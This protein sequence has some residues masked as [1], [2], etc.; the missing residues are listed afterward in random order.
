MEKESSDIQLCKFRE[1]LKAEQRK[2]AELE[3]NMNK[4]NNVLTQEH[5]Q[6]RD[7]E[8]K[9]GE[10]EEKL[11][12]EKQ[13]LSDFFKL[14]ESQKVSKLEE[15]LKRVTR[16]LEEERES[17]RKTAEGLEVLR[18]H[19]AVKSVHEADDMMTNLNFQIRTI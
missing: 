18:R 13:T 5:R 12:T 16:E 15:L 8:R 19:F 10:T 14:E 4:L 7:A 1:C 6:R 9:L 17:H 11:K 3:S 2:N